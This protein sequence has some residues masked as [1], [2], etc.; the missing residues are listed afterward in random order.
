[1]AR[2]LAVAGPAPFLSGAP[3]PASSGNPFNAS[4]SPSSEPN[5]LTPSTSVASP[6]SAPEQPVSGGSDA[7]APVDS[8]RRSYA[9]AKRAALKEKVQDIQ[10]ALVMNHLGAEPFQDKDRSKW[11]I[12]GV[13]NITVTGQKWWNLNLEKGGFGPINL[14]MHAKG[15]TYAETISWLA[16]EFNEKID[17]EDIK[18]SARDKAPSEKKTFDPPI[19]NERYLPFVKHYLHFQRALPLELIE[20]LIAQ[21][22]IYA[23]DDKNCIFYMEGIAEMR[24]SFDDGEV[25]KK[26]V[27]GST[28]NMGFLV[29]ADKN[30]NENCIAICESSI[31]SIS[32]R[33]LNPGRSAI[34]AAGA[35]REFPRKIAEE[36]IYNE[37]GVVA[38]FDADEAGDKASQNLFNHFYLKLWAQHR[39]AVDKNKPLDEE[40]MLDLMISGVIDFDLITPPGAPERNLLFFNSSTPFENPEQPPVIILNIKKNDIGLP[41]CKAFELPVSQKGYNYVINELNLRR[42]RPSIGKDWNEGLKASRAQSKPSI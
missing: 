24:S 15:L 14:V 33:A 7:Q 32:Y 5:G 36:A 6:P 35:G 39:L 40:A 42:D 38:A 17:D 34:S 18:A 19:R 22:K 30:L 10:V 27:T 8:P 4:L 31:D 1:M 21:R 28:R 41:E 2:Q 12:P 25:V 3:A 13:G 16:E 11:K 9:A 26:L 29:T 20:D 37:M 23:D